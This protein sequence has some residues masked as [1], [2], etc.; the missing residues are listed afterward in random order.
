VRVKV[1]SKAITERLDSE[2]RA[3]K[4]RF[5]A[6]KTAAKTASQWLKDNLKDLAKGFEEPIAAAVEAHKER[7]E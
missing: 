1:G 2:Q 7:A 3:Y 6:I 4:Q 5:D